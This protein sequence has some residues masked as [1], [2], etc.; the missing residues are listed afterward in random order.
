[1]AGLV[2]AEWAPVAPSTYKYHARTGFTFVSS[3]SN[4]TLGT[5]ECSVPAVGSKV[6][7]S[8]VAK[9]SSGDKAQ[10]DSTKDG[11]CDKSYLRSLGNE[12][13]SCRGFISQKCQSSEYFEAAN[14]PCQ[15]WKLAQ[16]LKNRVE[17]CKNEM[18]PN[19][20]NSHTGVG[21]FK[22]DD[23]PTPQLFMFCQA[24]PQEYTQGFKMAVQWRNGSMLFVDDERH[25][26]PQFSRFP[27][28]YE[29]NAEITDLLNPTAP[30]DI[31]YVHCYIPLKYSFK[32]IKIVKEIPSEELQVYA[33]GVRRPPSKARSTTP[34]PSNGEDDIDSSSKAVDIDNPEINE[35][36][37]SKRKGEVAP[38]VEDV[39]PTVAA[40]AGAQR[41]N[42][43]AATTNW[44]VLLS[45]GLTLA[46]S[47]VS[48]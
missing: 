34:V 29:V 22:T 28:G 39:D 18:D 27:A 38:T 7:I 37:L 31:L 33:A 30:T 13:T 16:F 46:F 32:W 19:G 1:M 21:Y 3:H 2:A 17:P 47:L 12:R 20:V 40:T 4:N 6:E 48:L 44:H 45:I 43:G 23:T 24:D 41:N 36:I 15:D 11:C 42:Y 14:S 25:R 10:D 8:L 35:N 9:G 26:I 5:Y